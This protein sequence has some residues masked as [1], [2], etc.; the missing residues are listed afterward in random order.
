MPRTRDLLGALLAKASSLGHADD[1][2]LVA[3][4]DLTR[5]QFAGEGPTVLPV[6]NELLAAYSARLDYLKTRPGSSA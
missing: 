3:I 1:P 4:A 5:A 2:T 6:V